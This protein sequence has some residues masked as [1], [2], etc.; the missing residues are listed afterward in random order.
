MS[1]L[2]LLFIIIIIIVNN[3]V[4]GCNNSGG[5]SSLVMFVVVIVMVMPSLTWTLKKWEKKK[6]KP[7]RITHRHFET[8]ICVQTLSLCGDSFF[9]FFL[10]EKDGKHTGSRS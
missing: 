9:N 8:N 4:E 10:T 2:L 1:L 6:G 7:G 3:E 5:S